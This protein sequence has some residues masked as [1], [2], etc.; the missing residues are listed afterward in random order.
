LKQRAI[1]ELYAHGK[2]LLTAEYTVLDGALALAV[3][4]RFGQSMKVKKT[5]KSDLVWYS[6][7]NTSEEWFKA[8]ISLMDFSAVKTSDESK[9]LYLQKLLKG[10]VRLNSEFLSK[11][12]GFDVKTYLE[13]PNNWGLGSSSTLT[14]LVAEW[15][16]VNPLL[17]HFQVSE[18]SGYDV[19]CAG[20]ESAI[21]YQLKDDT[22]NYSELDFD[23]SFKNKIYFVHLNRKASSQEAVKFYLTKVKRKSALIDRIS[24]LT[25]AFIDCNSFKVFT[26]IIDEH[27][28]IMS[29]ALQMPTVHSDLFPDFEGNIKSLGAWGGDFVMVCTQNSSDY[30]KDYFNARSYDTIL[31]YAD[32]IY[33]DQPATQ[34]SGSGV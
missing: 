6:Y 34:L 7:D 19:A 4:T 21:Q 25:E 24:E 29:E 13:F 22:I 32:M 27:E 11:W 17:L 8:Q 5:K 10:A 18:G 12:N 31:S 26:E 16:D 33:S 15:A 1:T 2:L 3:P 30:V 20:A 23:P 9:A 28:A 14:Y